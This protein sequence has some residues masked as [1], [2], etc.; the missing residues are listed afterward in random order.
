V[1]QNNKLN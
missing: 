1:E